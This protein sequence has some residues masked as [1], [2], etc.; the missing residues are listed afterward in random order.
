M[1]GL[2]PYTGPDKTLVKAGKPKASFAK[3][4]KEIEEFIKDPSVRLRRLVVLIS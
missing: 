3:A 4:I 2:N 1:T